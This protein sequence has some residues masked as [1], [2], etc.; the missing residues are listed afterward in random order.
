MENRKTETLWSHVYWL[1]V[2]G[3]MGSYSAAA[4]RLS[5][6]KAAVSHRIAQLEQAVGVPLVR[7][8]TR[9]VRLTEAGQQLVDSTRSAFDQIDSSYAG[10]KDLAAEP[11]GLVRVTAPVALGRQ[12]IVPLVPAFL[13]HYPDVRIEIELSDR[14]SSLAKEGFDLAIRHSASVPE[15]H[16]AWT[17]CETHSLLVATAEYLKRQGTPRH[18]DDL[19]LHNCLHYPRPGETPTWSFEPAKGKGE[20][21]SVPVRGSFSANNSEALRE[22]ALA[23][24]GIALV[25]DFTAQP[26]LAS[27]KLVVVL[28]KW[29]PVGGFSERLYAIRAYSPYVPRPVK[30]F[31]DYLRE[32]LSAG[33][34]RQ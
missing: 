7:R 30:A 13:R 22:C 5:V 21:I 34:L 25:P 11:R 20:R 29:R 26:E 24:L 10:V 17:L 3:A 1:G 8:T 28:P 6:S 18:P 23:G 12:Q 19:A 14:L 16:V 31:V 2:L 4:K 9:S 33:F 15:T 27:G 32:S